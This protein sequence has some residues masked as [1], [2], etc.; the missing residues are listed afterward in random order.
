V[1][2]ASTVNVAVD[3]SPPSQT[4]AV[5]PLRAVREARGLGLRQVAEEAGVDPAHL[6]R[7]ERG[8]AG[9]SVES[10]RRVAQALALSELD[11]LLA[12][13]TLDER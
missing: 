7:V 4:I 2:L 6:S 12:P 13:Y 11:R 5:P 10:L 3:L 1:V 8:Q 9:L